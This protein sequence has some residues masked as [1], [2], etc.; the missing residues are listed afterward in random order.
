[1]NVYL[2]QS[3]VSTR[4]SH[5]VAMAKYITIIKGRKLCGRTVLVQNVPKGKKKVPKNFKV[6]LQL[7][8]SCSTQG[9]GFENYIP[10]LTKL[11]LREGFTA[12][13]SF[14]NQLALARCLPYMYK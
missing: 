12:G 14:V 7:N 1:M 2:F 13:A 6:R 8:K 5:Y 9:R 3:P 11:K 4:F 10:V